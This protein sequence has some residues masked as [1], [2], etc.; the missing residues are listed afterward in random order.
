MR[1]GPESILISKGLIFTLQREA[2][3]FPDPGCLIVRVVAAPIGRTPS[4]ALSRVVQTG[5]LRYHYVGHCQI[6][7]TRTWE[8]A[9]D[10]RPRFVLPRRPLG[11][12]SN[13]SKQV[14]CVP[15][16]R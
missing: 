4:H 10:K 5:E 3:E 8:F 7:P 1:K 9:D 15:C 2:P 6:L 13:F 16:V 12:L 14:A 11:R